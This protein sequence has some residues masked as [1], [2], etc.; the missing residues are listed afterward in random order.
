MKLIRTCPTKIFFVS[1]GPAAS[2]TAKHGHFPKYRAS[3]YIA[4]L[5][6]TTAH[7]SNLEV[8]IRKKLQQKSKAT[9]LKIKL[10]CPL[11]PEYLLM[12]LICQD[13]V[14]AGESKNLSKSLQKLEVSSSHGE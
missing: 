10:F 4:Q 5:Q 8:R 14:A 13:V 11:L 6:A 12:V 1:N 9:L 2:R 3:H 7:C